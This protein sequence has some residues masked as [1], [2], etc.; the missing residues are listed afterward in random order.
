LGVNGEEQIV[1]VPL[2]ELDRIKGY[3][4]LS[5]VWV[6]KAND[7]RLFNRTFARLRE[8]V[9][10]LRSPDGCPWDREQTHQS[11]RKNLIEETCEVLDALDADE[12]QDMCEELGDL[13]LQV[14]LH[15][16]I[17]DEVGQFSALDIIQTLNE[18]LIRRHPHVF[19]Q[20]H[21]DDAEQ[22]LQ[23]WQQIKLE[24]KRGRGIDVEAQ[25]LLAG[26]PRELS[27]LLRA[28]KMQKKASTVGFDWSTY[29]D[30]W[31]KVEEELSEFSVAVDSG[32][33]SNIEDEFGDVLFALVNAARFLRIDPEAALA[34]TNRKFERRFAYIE[35]QLRVRNLDFSD[36][37]LEQMDVYWNEAKQQEFSNE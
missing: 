8:I 18:K 24:E 26:L 6:P 14:M 32:E 20:A 10:I 29:H 35:Q 37:T 15:A 31:A 11:I 36:V 12:P 27:S 7:E 21:A 19:G 16:Q 2:F 17:E 33:V 34:R 23:N 5:V 4:N 28:L 9:E 3:G 22:A 13:L 25:S 1:Q 30:I